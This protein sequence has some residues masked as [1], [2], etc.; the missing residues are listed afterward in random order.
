MNSE[1]IDYLKDSQSKLSV[2][3]LMDKRIFAVSK[4]FAKTSKRMT[5]HEWK[6]FVFILSEIDFTQE[7][8]EEVIVDK[9]IL[10]DAVGIH[11]DSNHL[12]SDLFLK[13]KGL[14]GNTLISLR[15]NIKKSNF[16]G[17]IISGIDFSDYGKITFQFNRQAL[18]Y[19]GNLQNGQYIV[20]WAADIFQMT[21]ARSAVF[22]EFLR[23]HSDTRLTNEYTIGIPQFKELFDIGKSGPGSYM[24]ANSGFDRSKFEE[25]VINPIV[26]DLR[27]CNMITLLPTKDG[28]YYEKVK[29]G[30]RVLGYRF[31]WTVFDTRT[32]KED[33]KEDINKKIDEIIYKKAQKRL[34]RHSSKNIEATEDDDIAIF[35]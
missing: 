27:G 17:N 1:K 11:S 24:R 16:C 8:P 28:K 22:Y 18:Y 15:D 35:F 21:S 32:I 29:Q 19:F 6:A 26:K 25:R 20:M 33:Q 34:E 5:I 2:S 30:N 4:S 12:S 13:I 23:L 31:R 9:K 3:P 7:C 10:A 14:T